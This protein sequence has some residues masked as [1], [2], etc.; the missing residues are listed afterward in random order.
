MPSPTS[1]VGNEL[2]FLPRSVRS[3]RHLEDPADRRLPGQREDAVAGE[4]PEAVRDQPLLVPLHAA[5]DMRAVAD[6]EVGARVDDGVRERAEVAAILAQV[7]LRA[8]RHM[9]LIG[10]LCTAVKRHD[11]EVGPFGGLA[12][13]LA[14]AAGCR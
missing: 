7:V 14:C 1:A 9:L 10:A 3:Q 4:V 11:D 2:P 6:Y 13:Q 12:D 5:Q 8:G